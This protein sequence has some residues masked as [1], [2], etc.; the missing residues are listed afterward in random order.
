MEI[1]IKKIA[2]QG[3]E[4]SFHHQVAATLFDKNIPLEECMS[5]EILVKS[6]KQNTSQKGIMALEN[7]IAGS[8]I[9]NYALIDANDL[10]I[11]GEYYLD[12]HMNLMVLKGQK[13]EDITEVHSHPIAL[14]QCGV[15][16][17]NYPH[18]KLVESGDTAETARRIQQEKL[19][20]IGAIASP[21]AAKMYDLDIIASGIHTIKS[22]K[23]RFVIVKTQNKEI[24]KEQINKASI[25]FEL[26]DTPGNLATILNV[27]NNCKLNLTKI[28]SMPIIET[29]F[30]YSFFVDIVF[31]KYK[32]YEKAK[33]ILE[34]MTTH[35]KVLGEYKKGAQ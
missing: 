17:K 11:I 8:I 5:F 2:I 12:I 19:T 6:L 34:L 30:Q 16:F 10:H 25:K 35:F 7:S 27:M 26:D 20:G 32:H 21:I 22:N 1:E 13:I 33:K 15:F 28:Q 18:I 24:S 14:L 4:G 23:T 31:A 3:I 29:P 9:P